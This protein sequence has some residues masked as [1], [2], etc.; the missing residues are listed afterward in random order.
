MLLSFR[1]DQR[2]VLLA[3]LE[4]CKHNKVQISLSKM[5]IWV[6]T[7]SGFP[8]AKIDKSKVLIVQKKSMLDDW[9]HNIFILRFCVSVTQK[10]KASCVKTK[11]FVLLVISMTFVRSSASLVAMWCNC[12]PKSAS[13][14]NVYRWR[15]T[16][17][18]LL[19]SKIHSS[20]THSL[21]C[22]IVVNVQMSK[23]LSKS[24]MRV[25]YVN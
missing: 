20:G 17:V 21:I 22:A 9:N 3:E 6:E 25:C 2:S 10:L 1:K 8:L 4:R 11:T 13:R 5:C 24:P 7:V 15:T 19:W 12:C 18:E 23:I 14:L 16:V